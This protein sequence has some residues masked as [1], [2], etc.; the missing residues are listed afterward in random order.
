MVVFKYSAQNGAPHHPHF[1]LPTPTSTPPKLSAAPQH[2]VC[3]KT[4][5]LVNFPLATRIPAPSPSPRLHVYCQAGVLGSTVRSLCST[6]ASLGKLF[7]VT[8]DK[9]PNSTCL[10]K[11]IQ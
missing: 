7:K 6:T 11:S 8:G 9:A 1:C 5:C 3:I 2:Q 4:V 10:G